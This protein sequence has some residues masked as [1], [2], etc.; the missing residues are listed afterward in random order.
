MST[1]PAPAALEDADLVARVLGGDK[2][3]YEVIVRRHN[4]RLFRAARAILR[5]DHEAEDVVQQV[6][7]AAYQKLDGF[8]GEAAL[9]TWLTR[10]VVNE[11]LGRR[12]R[13]QRGEHL[14]IVEEERHAMNPMPTPEEAAADGELGRLLE[15]QIDRLPDIY[16]EVLV[17]RDVEEMSTAE[18]AACLGVSEETVRVRLFRARREM[19]SALSEAVGVSM[20][21]AFRFAGERCDRITAGVMA[22]IARAR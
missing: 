6:W 4:Q 12:R 22:A 15:A 11:A 14:A 19:Q 5:D 8:R 1:T 13:Q 21:S 7:V 17:L 18:T 16:R 3:V 2:A 20:S 9:S 10:I